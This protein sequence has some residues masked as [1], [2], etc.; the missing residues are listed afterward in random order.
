MRIIGGKFR[1][2]KIFFDNTQITRPLR[3]FVRE[4]IFNLIFHGKNNNIDFEKSKILD[5]YSGFGSFGLECL[6][7]N[8]KSVV[9]VEKDKNA[10]KFIKKNLNNLKINKN[11]EVIN[12]DVKRYLEYTEHETKF[13]I[14]FFDP[15]YKDGSF[16]EVLEI[17]KKKKIINNKHLIIIHRERKSED[18]FEKIINI[19]L[20]KHYG[21]SK[22]IFGSF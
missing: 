21:R 19:N 20:L 2:K 3:D 1:G 6:S 16:L 5:L 7:R 14:F 9:F 17:I 11:V 22:V 10:F 18:N 4:N 12:L 15:P 8:A 13:D